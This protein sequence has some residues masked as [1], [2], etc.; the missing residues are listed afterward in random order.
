MTLRTQNHR[1]FVSFCYSIKPSMGMGKIWRA[2]KSLLTRSAGISTDFI[3][4]P[5]SSEIKLSR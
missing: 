3:T 5:G 4:D 2:V 1:S